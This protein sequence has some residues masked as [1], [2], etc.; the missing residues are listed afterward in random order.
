MDEAFDGVITLTDEDGVESDFELYDFVEFNDQIYLRLIPIEQETGDGEVSEFI[1]L[2]LVQDK[3]DSDECLITI[4]GEELDT[5]IARFEEC[6]ADESE[7]L[8]DE[9]DES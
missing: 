3:E 4:E 6:D 7:F 2:K 9:D 1:I 8:P 5:V